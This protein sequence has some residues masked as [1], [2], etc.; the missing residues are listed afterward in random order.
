MAHFCAIA[1]VIVQ[2]AFQT[3]SYKAPKAKI[4]QWR[5]SHVYLTNLNNDSVWLLRHM[6]NHH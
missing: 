4:N 2:G 1:F 3:S 5:E 6:V